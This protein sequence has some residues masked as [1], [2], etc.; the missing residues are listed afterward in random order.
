[1]GVYEVTQDEYKSVMGRNPSYFSTTGGGSG[2]VRGRNT[3]NF[4]VDYVSWD[5]TQAF[6]K[7]LSEQ[8]GVRY[9]L[10][11]EAEWEYACRAGTT[12][13]FYWGTEN[14]GTQSNSK[15]RDPDGTTL[16]RTT[17]VGSYGANP[18]GLHDMHGNVV[19]WC[20]DW[21]DAND[22]GN[23]P[24]ED[25]QGPASG[26][27]R[28]VRGGSWYNENRYSRAA[29]RVGGKPGNRSNSDVGFRVVSESVRTP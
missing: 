9:R 12:T 15:G 5:D 8:D 23:S 22:Y 21:F 10:P 20:S 6:C 14:N 26:S 29:N 4:P 27:G 7:R 3:S 19:E 25:P 11:T 28:V 1:M 18:F 24:S 16:K 13:P 2:A 17:T